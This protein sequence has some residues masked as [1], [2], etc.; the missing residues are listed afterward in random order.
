MHGLIIRPKSLQRYDCF[1][2]YLTWAPPFLSVRLFRIDS[3]TPRPLQR[4]SS[5]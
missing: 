5:P 4:D 3:Y 2:P 1:L